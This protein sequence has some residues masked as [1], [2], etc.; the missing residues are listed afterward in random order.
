MPHVSLTNT[1]KPC[2]NGVGIRKR[3]EVSSLRLFE[4]FT[5]KR[6]AIVVLGWRLALYGAFNLVYDRPLYALAIGFLGTRG[7]MLMTL[8][9]LLQNSYMFWRYDRN[10]LDWLFVN[11]VDDWEVREKESG[12][13]T[14]FQKTGVGRSIVGRCISWLWQLPR[15]VFLWLAIRLLRFKKSRYGI[16]AIPALVLK[17]DPLIVAVHY[18]K[19]GR[20]AKPRDWGVLLFTVVLAN[21]YWGVQIEFLVKILEWLYRHF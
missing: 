11:A 21:L 13:P 3:K 8:G 20:G 12:E 16:L 18:K 7:W 2:Y 15:Y 14:W 6:E 5:K 19:I 9:S 1:Y 17:L 10:N 4:W